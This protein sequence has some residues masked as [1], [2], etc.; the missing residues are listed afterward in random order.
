MEHSGG[1]RA[2]R[3]ER[4]RP[5]R[6][7]KGG[8]TRRLTWRYARVHSAQLCTGRAGSAQRLGGRGK[9]ERGEGADVFGNSEAGD[10]ELRRWSGGRSDAV[11]TV[12]G[13]VE[14]A[15]D[16]AER[17]RAS[18]FEFGDEVERS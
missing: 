11:S 18:E 5:G 10:D 13:A 2:Q 17:V 6:A 3:A 9:E 8:G 1:G 14:G 4:A 7:R 16:E 15:R 12:E